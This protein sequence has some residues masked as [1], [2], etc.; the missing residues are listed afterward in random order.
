MNINNIK[1]YFAINYNKIESA[2]V[3]DSLFSSNKFK[4]LT[5]FV[6]SIYF[7]VSILFL[8]TFNINSLVNI[9]INFAFIFV[10]VFSASVISFLIFGF[11]EHKA[12]SNASRFIK[13]LLLGFS[14]VFVITLMLFLYVHFEQSIESSNYSFYKLLQETIIVMIMPILLLVFSYENYLIRE[15][16]KIITKINKR[17]DVEKERIVT[18]KSDNIKE[19]LKININDFIYAE[20]SDNYTSIFYK[21]G[22][23][24]SKVLFRLTLKKLENQ[25]ESFDL[26]IRCH[27]S[28]LVNIN[29]IK[30]ISGTS[31]NYRIIL[32]GVD[33]QIPVSRNFPKTVIDSLKERQRD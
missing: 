30:Q 21:N 23:K 10:I 18:V 33:I 3:G 7:S 9:I 15:R 8:G 32:F 2:F 25:F 16:L 22:D 11:L 17:E 31:Q 4:L 27:K 6:L 13:Y 1:S 19:S 12:L 5:S 14:E 28:F 20:S 26:T 24:V 29:Q